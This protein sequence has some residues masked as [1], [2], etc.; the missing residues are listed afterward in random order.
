MAGETEIDPEVYPVNFNEF[1]I[2]KKM[3]LWPHT[4]KNWGGVVVEGA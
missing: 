1:K 4:K 2:Q 3:F